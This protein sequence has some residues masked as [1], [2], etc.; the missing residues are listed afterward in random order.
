[1]TSKPCQNSMC[2]VDIGKHLRFCAINE[3]NVFAKLYLE[4]LNNARLI[5]WR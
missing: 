3:W 5:E 4:C 1:M 2:Q